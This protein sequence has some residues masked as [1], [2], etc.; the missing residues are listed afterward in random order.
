MWRVNIN[1][2]GEAWK[3]SGADFKKMVAE[4]Q[5]YPC[6]LIGSKKLP[7]GSRVMSYK[8]EEISEVESFQEACA[9]F[10][11]FTTDFEAL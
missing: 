9:K 1:C 4:I 10:A 6:E 7:D 11:G 3:L 5:G 8:M 2:D